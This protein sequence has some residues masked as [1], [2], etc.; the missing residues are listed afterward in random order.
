MDGVIIGQSLWLILEAMASDDV[1]NRAA[2][3][4]M[5]FAKCREVKKDFRERMMNSVCSRV[6]IFCELFI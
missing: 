3:T 5:E 6:T 1:K 2:V 4:V